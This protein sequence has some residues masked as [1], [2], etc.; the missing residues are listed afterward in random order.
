MEFLKKNWAK[1]TIA[2]L[3]FLAG[4]FYLIAIFQAPSGVKLF[5]GLAEYIAGLVFFWGVTAFLVSKLLG[6]NWAKWVLLG[7]G[8]LGTTF[9]MAALIWAAD[10]YNF[11][12]TF[13]WL[14][15]YFAFLVI[16]GLIPLVKGIKKVCCHCDKHEVKKA[17]AKTTTT[18]AK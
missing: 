11:L 3:T 5:E 10:T 13:T 17:P 1:C 9:A 16:F 4:L 6:Q 18:T 14:A 15:Q 12:K 8:I 7:T 2:V